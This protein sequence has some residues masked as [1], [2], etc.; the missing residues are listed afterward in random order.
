LAGAILLQEQTPMNPLD[1][2]P[3]DETNLSHSHDPNAYEGH[4]T[5]SFNRLIKDGYD[6]SSLST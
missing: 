1:A 3:T 6:K 5:T 4:F 2:L